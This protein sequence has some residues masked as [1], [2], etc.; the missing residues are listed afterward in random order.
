MRIIELLRLEKTSKIIKSNHQP[1][2]PCLL[3]PK[4]HIYTFFKHLQGSWLHHFPGQPVPVLDNPISEERKY[5]PNTQ[6]KPLLVQL[7]AWCHQPLLLTPTTH[8]THTS[9]FEEE[10]WQTPPAG[11]HPRAGDGAHAPPWASLQP[12]QHC[13]NHLRGTGMV[14]KIHGVV[15]LTPSARAAAFRNAPVLPLHPQLPSPCQLRP[16]L[17]ASSR[18]Q[19]PPS[20]PAEPREVKRHYLRS[21]P[22]LQVQLIHS[23]KLHSFPSYLQIHQ[24]SLKMDGICWHMQLYSHFC[25][26]YRTS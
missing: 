6:F 5:F 10:R 1:N 21:P 24:S 25:S 17:G 7:E 18:T 3:I 12:H 19:A 26:L 15:S 4:C 23:R 13:A 11:E 20:E 22:W 14:T 9:T 16:P 8:S 2:T